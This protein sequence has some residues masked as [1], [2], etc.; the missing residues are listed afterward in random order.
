[1]AQ[2]NTLLAYAQG[3]G[4]RMRKIEEEPCGSNLNNYY[5]KSPNNMGI[6]KSLSINNANFAVTDDGGGEMV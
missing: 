5:Y 3:S 1:M 6:I 4:F 2:Q